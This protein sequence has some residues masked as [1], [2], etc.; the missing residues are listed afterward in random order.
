MGM[1]GFLGGLVAGTGRVRLRS[2]VLPPTR[3]LRWRVNKWRRHLRHRDRR[4]RPG[5]T[6]V[7]AC[8][9]AACGDGEKDDSASIEGSVIV[10]GT[11]VAGA[12]VALDAVEE[13]EDPS[14]A[15]E[16]DPLAESTA[17]DDGAFRFAD[18]DPGKCLHDS[19]AT[20]WAG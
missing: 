10:Q 4:W 9:S 19:R 15:A 14:E 16:G 8:L 17:D 3:Q 11:P 1:L 7:V 12:P 20:G 6:G 18:L 13:G 5:L 2:L